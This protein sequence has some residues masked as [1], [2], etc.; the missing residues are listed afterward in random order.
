MIMRRTSWSG[1]AMAAR[2]GDT[3]IN[4]GQ[5]RPTGL[6]LVRARKPDADSTGRTARR[7][8][9]K[10]QS[11]HRKPASIKHL[12]RCHDLPRCVFFVIVAE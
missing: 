4:T 5:A 1:S 6:R 12:P 2:P 7:H 10:K 8:E 3:Q 11:W 9:A